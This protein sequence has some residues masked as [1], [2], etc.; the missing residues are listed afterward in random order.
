MWK[1][2]AIAVLATVVVQQDNVVYAADTSLT[3]ENVLHAI[4]RGRNYIISKQQPNGSWRGEKTSFYRVGITSLCLLSLMDAG[5]TAD[6]R[7]IDNGLN[8]LRETKASAPSYTYEISLMIMAF[9]AAKDGGKDKLRIINLVKKLEEGQIKQGENSGGWGYTCQGKGS[10]RSNTEY[11]IRGLRD[12]VYYGVPV[13]QKVWKRACKHW[14]N[15]QNEDGSWGYNSREREGSGNMTV[16]GISSLS[17]VSEFLQDQQGKGGG[18]ICC[19]PSETGKPIE[20]AV[21]WLTENFTIDS[22]PPARDYWLSYLC[23]LERASCLSGRRFFGSHDW[24]REGAQVL[25]DKQNEQDGSWQG[26]GVLEKTPVIGTSFALQFLSRGFAPVLINKMQLG[27]KAPD[28]QEQALIELWNQHPRDVHNLVEYISQQPKWPRHLT[29]QTF[30]FDKAV[31]NDSI[32]QMMQSP[33]L[34]VTFEKASSKLMGDNHFKMLRDYLKGGGFLFV[35]GSSQNKSSDQGMHQL[36]E[37]L[38]PDKTT[39]LMPLAEMHPVFCSEYLLNPK[40]VK[41]FGADLGSRTAI[42]YSPDDLSRLWDK[43]MVTE[44]ANCNQKLKSEIDRSLRI[45]ANIVAYATGRKLP[46]KLINGP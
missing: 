15:S 17:I 3:T 11:A 44:P 40:T 5:M 19:Q 30:D 1:Q 13:D 10:D 29:W 31:A 18:L 12:A 21:R 20:R 8:W 41:L 38:F 33:I 46:N 7:T 35:S 32:Q 36:V 25:L 28:N 27:P 23:G 16:A 22:N 26:V 34:F 42:I 4:K 43:R 45:G 37:R 6:D 9:T 24:F 39:S 14:L 2:I